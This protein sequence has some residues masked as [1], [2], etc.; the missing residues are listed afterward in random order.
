MSLMTWFELP[1]H[2]LGSSLKYRSQCSQC[3]SFISLDLK[4][5][6][7][8][9]RICMHIL[10]CIQVFR[11]WGWKINLIQKEYIVVDYNTH[12]HL[13]CHLHRAN[14]KIKVLIER[15]QFKQVIFETWYMATAVICLNFIR[16][17][18]A[19]A[20]SFRCWYMSILTRCFVY[21]FKKHRVNKTNDVCSVILPV[22]K[23][24]ILQENETNEVWKS[25]LKMTLSNVTCPHGGNNFNLF[26]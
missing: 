21:L 4:F 1:I 26:E 16:L 20:L 18:W 3:S 22:Y 8:L 11:T 5:T 15:E 12:V 9:R 7:Y 13:C 10:Y 6:V 25:P 23:F 17:S 24:S 14:K 2:V 19:L